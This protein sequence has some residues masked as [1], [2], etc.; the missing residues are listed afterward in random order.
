VSG[1]VLGGL[2]GER[3]FLGVFGG[4]GAGG[5]GLGGGV[6]GSVSNV[7]CG[8]EASFVFVMCFQ[9]AVMWGVCVAGCL[10]GLV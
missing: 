2:G 1:G 6:F 7:C 5:G 8:V 4:R 3:W 10:M 9:R